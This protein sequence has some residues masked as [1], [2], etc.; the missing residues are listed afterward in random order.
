MGATAIYACQ[1]KNNN[2]R[3][4]SL[5]MGWALACWRREMAPKVSVA[6]RAKV[7]IFILK[8]CEV[9]PLC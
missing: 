3:A 7:V 4:C 8:S 6:L 9:I 2:S 5:P 1:S